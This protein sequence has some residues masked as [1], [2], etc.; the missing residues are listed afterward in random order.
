MKLH[1]LYIA[2]LISAFTFAQKKA[3][4]TL[5]TKV[6]NV[7][8]PFDPS[9]SDAFKIQKNP[10]LETP[11][12]IKHSQFNYKIF[13]VPVASTFIS[14]RGTF[15]GL[16]HPKLPQIHNNFISVGYGND[17]TPLFE[18]FIHNNP[19]K[20]SDIGAFINM[21]SSNPNIKNS[22]LDAS[23][24]DMKIDAFYKQSNNNYDWQLNSGL[25]FQKS[26]WYGLGGP[27][28][29][30]SSYANSINPKQDYTNFYVGGAMSYF[31]A[32]FEGGTFEYSFFSDDYKTTE[33]HFYTT[34]QFAFPLS[35]EYLTTTFSIDYL[36][37]KFN[38]GYVNP[39]P[40]SYSFFNLGV[41]PNLEVL[42]KD[43]IFNLGVK[44]YYSSPTAFEQE[45]KFLAYPN[46]TATYKKGMV[47]FSGGVTGDLHQ[48]SYKEFANDNPFVSPTLNIKR[49]DE[50][51]KAF[52]GLKGIVQN[53]SY[54]L[55]VSYKSE[56]DKPLFILNPVKELSALNRAYSYGNSFYVLYDDVKT[57]SF[58]ANAEVA[59]D[60]N[61]T[62]GG[63]LNINSYTLTNTS[64]AWNLPTLKA[65]IYGKY[66]YKNWFANTHIYIVGERKDL[67]SNLFPT[68]VP[69]TFLP[70]TNDAYVDVNIRGGYY[71]SDRL[72]A[73]AKFNNILGNDYQKFTNFNVQGFQALAGITYK[74]DF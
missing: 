11:K 26:N 4:D 34:P 36:D 49:T 41:A 2:L 29:I 25:Q 60:K 13:S 19:T 30:A 12:T 31:N 35:S 69:A 47:T 62:L 15:V 42:R 21:K 6:I 64:E 57:F 53:L 56:K 33:S 73:F 27:L 32:Y 43:F 28:S 37:G 59:Y 10:S 17:N 16:K 46:I 70:V 65:E 55:Q 24:S 45:S 18:A 54:E 72:S 5:K 51:Y 1:F 23:Y 52:V 9:V 48:N 58:T 44:V 68:L 8:K 7:V 50:Q 3:K 38:T 71:F 63:R 61:L 66:V 20:T 67:P 74:F 40:I 22:L 39:N 14:K